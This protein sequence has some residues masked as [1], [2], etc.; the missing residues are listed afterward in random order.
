M[1]CRVAAINACL[2]PYGPDF[3]HMYDLKTLWYDSKMS[4]DHVDHHSFEKI[5][6]TPMEHVSELEPDVQ[7]LVEEMKK[8]KAKFQELKG[9]KS[10]LAT[11][12]LRKS[13]K[14]VLSVLMVKKREDKEPKFY[15][16]MNMEVSLAVVVL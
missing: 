9:V 2:R 6:A 7:L 11:F 5:Q 14:P 4:L 3:L 10:E 8:H 16:G 1:T 15:Y 13:Q 12:W